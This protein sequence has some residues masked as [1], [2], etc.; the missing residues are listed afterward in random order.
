MSNQNN[1]DM[2][3]Q[4]TL[5]NLREESS[6]VYSA[7]QLI[8]NFYLFYIGVLVVAMIA[9]VLFSSRFAAYMQRDG[10]DRLF[11]S[12]LIQNFTFK[13]PLKADGSFNLILY[14]L[15]CTLNI[16]T[17]VIYAYIFHTLLQI[18]RNIK[19]GQSP[20]TLR[21]TGY[22]RRCYQIFAVFTV[23]SFLSSIL[24]RGLTLSVFLSSL[25][26][27]C[28]FLSLA[29]IFEYGSQLQQESDETL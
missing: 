2:T 20:F 1:L 19:S 6:N 15:G 3:K 29:L 28:F 10:A 11:L 12:Q 22:W 5:E 23:L 9:G 4:K 25:L 24:F 18:F 17:C 21:N 13:H 27:A 16:G 7:V 8:R 26:Y 14:L